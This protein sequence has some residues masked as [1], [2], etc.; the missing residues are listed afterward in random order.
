M[1]ERPHNDYPAGGGGAGRWVFWG[2]V[3]IAAYFLLTEHSAHIVQ[4]LPYLLVLACP[5]IHLFH[6]H[7]SHGGHR[8]P[9]DA[10]RNEKTART[11]GRHPGGCH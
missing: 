5:L 11:D 9:P 3:L 8:E 7:G 6:G 4:Y 10:N 1:A 2:F